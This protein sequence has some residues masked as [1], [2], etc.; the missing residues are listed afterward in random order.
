M[1]AC[2]GALGSEAQ[3]L[4]HLWAAWHLW[5]TGDLRLFD[6]PGPRG[7]P[8]CHQKM[9]WFRFLGTQ[10]PSLRPRG[11]Q[12]LVRRAPRGR[13]VGCAEF[14]ALVGSRLRE[15]W[16]TLCSW[17]AQILILQ[18]FISVWLYLW[19]SFRHV[20]NLSC[21]LNKAGHVLCLCRACS[22]LPWSS[23]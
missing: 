16:G 19:Q 21:H 3:L 15:L 17:K 20:I 14:P 1:P 2:G 10:V 13:Q 12:S 9:V 8:R 22:L 5:S 4:K 6:S 7:E 18:R 11:T 23:I